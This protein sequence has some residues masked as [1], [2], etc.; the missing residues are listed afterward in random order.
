LRRRPAKT[1]IAAMQR[2]GELS[3]E[4]ALLPA[5]ME[6]FGPLARGLFVCECPSLNAPI[7]NMFVERFADQKRCKAV[8]SIK[9]AI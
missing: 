4:V 2:I 6:R 7:Q 9:T 5:R 1:K 8:N 3:M